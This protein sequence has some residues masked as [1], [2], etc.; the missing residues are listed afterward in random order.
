MFFV[1][2][3]LETILHNRGI[4]LVKIIS[5]KKRQKQINLHLALQ[6]FLKNLGITLYIPRLL[7]DYKPHSAIYLQSGF[8]S[9]NKRILCKNAANTC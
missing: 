6:H 5:N 9:Q 3:A 2:I 7:Q 8:L 4:A 1:C